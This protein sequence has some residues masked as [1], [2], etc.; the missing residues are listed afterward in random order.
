MPTGWPGHHHY[1]RNS[2]WKIL[3]FGGNWRSI[4]IYVLSSYLNK[5]LIVFSPSPH[6]LF[7]WP[8]ILLR[9]WAKV[10]LEPFITYR[11]G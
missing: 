6:Y 11:L 9:F 5:E 7:P 10:V 4:H 2:S 3:I 1:R 8:P